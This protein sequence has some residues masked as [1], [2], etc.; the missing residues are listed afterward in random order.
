ME[1]IPAVETKPLPVPESRWERVLYLLIVIGLPIICFT[2]SDVLKPEWQ[3]GKFSDYVTLMLLPGVSIFFFPFIAY[4]MLCMALLLIAPERFAPRFIVRFGIYTGT[5]LALQYSIL[6]AGTDFII[7]SAVSS[8]ILIL[9]KWLL[10]KLKSTLVAIGIFLLLFILAGIVTMVWRHID[11][12]Q[13]LFFVLIGILSA[14]PF[15]CL[16]VAVLTSIKLL[17][18]YETKSFFFWRGMGLAAWLASYGLAWRF[19][20]LKAIEV[21]QAL[22]PAPPDCYIATAAA[23]G[24]KSIVQAR[25]VALQSGLVWVNPQLQYLKCAE[26]ALIALVPAIH[27]PLRRIYDLVGRALAHRLTNSFLADLAYLT[28]KP[29]EWLT[30][31]VLKSLIPE[32]DMVARSLYARK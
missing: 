14:S 9:G 29:F 1:P 21:Y 15:L 32:I 5:V 26:L 16:A 18:L 31:F 19:S 12:P 4:A 23:R 22:P 25:P 6:T 17:K 27:R 2:L 11:L 28:L 7:I 20:V 8:A 10:G 24:H 3:S 13:F 30:R